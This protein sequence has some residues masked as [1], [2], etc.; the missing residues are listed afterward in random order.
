V[1]D[2]PPSA[3]LSQ[4]APHTRNDPGQAR[5]GFADEV[6]E[7]Q[8][9]ARPRPAATDSVQVREGDSLWALAAATL[10]PDADNSSI[11]DRWHEIYE[12]NRGVI[13]ADPDLILPG[14]TLDLPDFQEDPR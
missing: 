6:V 13:G 7:R 9:A 2:A 11:A 14:T 5:E 1:D 3:G 10:P 4:Q 8:G 12:M